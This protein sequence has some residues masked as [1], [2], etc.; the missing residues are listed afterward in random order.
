M[1]CH[2]VKYIKGS[3]WKRRVRLL[4]LIELFSRCLIAGVSLSLH[5]LSCMIKASCGGFQGEWSR[6]LILS[7]TGNWQQTG[8]FI[9]W[10]ENMVCFSQEFLLSLSFS[11]QILFYFV[12]PAMGVVMRKVSWVCCRFHLSLFKVCCPL[13]YPVFVHICLSQCDVPLSDKNVGRGQE[14]SIMKHDNTSK[15]R[16]RHSFM[17]TLLR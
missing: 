14:M 2:G 12:V 13:K 11:S 4:K 5:H 10:T 1:C 8:S 16:C 7:W 9:N 15:A 17:F 3:G 6:I